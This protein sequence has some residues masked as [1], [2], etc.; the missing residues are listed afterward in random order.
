MSGYVYFVRPIDAEG[1]VKIGWSASPRARLDSLMAWSPVPLEVAAKSPSDD[2]A[3]E[4]QVQGHF[5]HLWSHKEWFR[6]AP[7]LS[8][9]IAKVA[10][11]ARIEDCV[12]LN[13]QRGKMSSTRHGVDLTPMR[14]L[15]LSYNG[16]LRGLREK[17]RRGRSGEVEFY[18]LPDDVAEIISDWCGCSYAYNYRAPIDPSPE[19]IA[20]LDAVLADPLAH[21]VPVLRRAAA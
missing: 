12:D 8:D 11:G 6:A 10:A 2:K 15:F 17:A 5:F 3:L 9:A 14:R 21:L 16:R 1:P 20:R 13:I 19:Q 7:D 4:T 18:R